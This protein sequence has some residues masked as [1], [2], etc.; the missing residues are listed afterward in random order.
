MEQR[1]GLSNM[2]KE[3]LKMFRYDLP[4]T[5]LVEIKELLAKYFEN[6]VDKEMDELW[7]TKG[8]SDA[9]MDSWSKEHMRKKK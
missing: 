3:L 5:Q 9:Q 4:D 6:K 2:Q 1:I 7:N 8:W